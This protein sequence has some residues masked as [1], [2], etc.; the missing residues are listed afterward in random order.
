MRMYKI[1]ESKRLALGL[2]QEELG[3]LA[4]VSNSTVGN[5]EAGK[6]ASTPVFN[7]IKMAIDNELNA[8]DKVDYIEKMLMMH[9]IQLQQ[10]DNDNERIMCLGF[11]SIYSNKLQMELLK[12]NSKRD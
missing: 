11:I 12:L 7:S 8:L 2:T 9:T 4:G 10:M 5:L 1:L 3:R 6:E